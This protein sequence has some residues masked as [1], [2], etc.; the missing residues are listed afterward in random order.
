VAVAQSEF[1]GPDGAPLSVD[2]GAP[3][4]TIPGGRLQLSGNRPN[5]FSAETHFTLD[6]A[7]PGDVE[8]GI[9]DLRGATVANLF[10][11]HLPAGP[12]EFRWTGRAADGS[13]VA[14]GVYF[15]RVAVGGKTL[16]RKLILVRGN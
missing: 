3:S 5:P 16:G 7:E 4:G 11:G 9:Y 10:R 1:S 6:L 8:V 15:Y 14:N 2:L 13:T 12:H